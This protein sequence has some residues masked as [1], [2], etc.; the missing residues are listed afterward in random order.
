MSN[1]VDPDEM[2]HYEPSH[3]DL[4]YLQK[5]YYYRQWQWKSQQLSSLQHYLCLSQDG[6]SKSEI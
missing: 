1:S 3:Q 2:A 6:V 5:T 4:C